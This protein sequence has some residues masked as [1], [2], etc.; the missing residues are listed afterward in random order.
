M[1]IFFSCLLSNLAL[2]TYF[3]SALLVFVP[4]LLMK[5]SGWQFVGLIWKDPYF[6]LLP[7]GTWS[8][9]S[10]APM[11]AKCLWPG[12]LLC[13][14]E[15]L[16]SWVA[17]GYCTVLAA[18]TT[19]CPHPSLYPYCPSATAPCKTQGLLG[20][21]SCSSLSSA[22]LCHF[23]PFFPFHTPGGFFCWKE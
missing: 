23:L 17:A 16:G 8:G 14:A 7:R 12:C 6:N 9:Q 1:G 22:A 18:P 19:L 11:W 21:N 13:Q 15:V 2:S 5:M 3:L 10:L 4:G 20:F